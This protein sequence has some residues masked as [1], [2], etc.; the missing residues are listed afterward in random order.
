MKGRRVLAKILGEV[1]KGGATCSSTS[2]LVEGL[3]YYIDCVCCCCCHLISSCDTS[4]S[5][6]PALPCAFG[7]VEA[8]GK[9][10]LLFEGR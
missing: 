3:R 2:L 4:C 5:T 10:L 6:R 9:L 1:A 8:R 7:R